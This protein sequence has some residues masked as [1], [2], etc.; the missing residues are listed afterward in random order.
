MEREKKIMICCLQFSQHLQLRKMWLVHLAFL[1]SAC[2]LD[3]DMKLEAKKANTQEC[4]GQVAERA[5]SNVVNILYRDLIFYPC[6]C[7]NNTKTSIY[8][9][10]GSHWEREANVKARTTHYSSELHLLFNSSSI[11]LTTSIWESGFYNIDSHV[12]LVDLQEWG[13]SQH[14]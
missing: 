11:I 10:S 13:E 12:K 9:N 3:Q 7:K 6:F 5:G 14:L 4:S 1:P 8:F 2:S